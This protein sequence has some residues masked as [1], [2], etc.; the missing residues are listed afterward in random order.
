MTPQAEGS[1]FACKH[2]EQVI[3]SYL[4]FT[5]NKPSEAK[6]TPP[7]PMV[8]YFPHLL[9]IHIHMCFHCGWILHNLCSILHSCY[10]LSLP[11]NCTQLL[12][13]IN[14]QLMVVLVTAGWHL[15][16]HL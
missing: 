16:K 8:P 2:L 1:Y 11:P 7:P 13:L 4:H 5:E 9:L 6:A 12:K 10:R 14:D 3:T 15:V